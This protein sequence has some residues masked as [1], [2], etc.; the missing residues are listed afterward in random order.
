[1]L[2]MLA[3]PE[4]LVRTVSPYQ[5]YT[6][7]PVPN[8]TFFAALVRITE[9]HKKLDAYISCFALCSENLVITRPRIFVRIKQAFFFIKKR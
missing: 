6:V 7:V 3:L 8:V 4:L 9:L 2:L 5:L 1:M